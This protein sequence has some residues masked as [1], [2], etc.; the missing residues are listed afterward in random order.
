MPQVDGFAVL[1]YLQSNLPNVRAIMLSMYDDDEHVKNAILAGATGYVVK[2]DAFTELLRAINIVY[3]DG[4]YLGVAIDEHVFLSSGMHQTEMPVPD[5][6]ERE[7]AI[8]ELMC[9]DLNYEKIAAKMFLSIKTV[10]ACRHQLFTRFGVKSRAGLIVAAFAGGI[11][12]IPRA[13]KSSHLHMG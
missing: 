4:I 11:I 1:K 9:S 12:A 10:E 8:L 5:L 13:D 7:R 2:G 6:T 3:A